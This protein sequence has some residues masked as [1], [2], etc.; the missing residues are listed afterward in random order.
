MAHKLPETSLNAAVQRFSAAAETIKTLCQSPHLSQRSC[1]EMS[2]Y[3]D[4]FFNKI[5][6]KGNLKFGA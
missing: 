1:K 5:G 4:S 6:S 3:I 2:G